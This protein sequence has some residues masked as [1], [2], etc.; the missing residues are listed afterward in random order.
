VLSNA[1]GVYTQEIP[2]GMNIRSHLYALDRRHH[3][4]VNSQHE[5]AANAA[6][7]LDSEAI[8]SRPRTGGHA[9]DSLLAARWAAQEETSLAR[10]A[11]VS[12]DR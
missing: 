1:V 5:G 2:F 8:G 4:T 11:R 10:V 6:S 12:N 7:K 3:H 9:A